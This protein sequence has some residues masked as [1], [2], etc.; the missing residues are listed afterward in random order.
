MKSPADTF[1]LICQHEVKT[2]LN[3]GQGWTFIRGTCST[4]W[5]TGPPRGVW[6]F[7]FE[8]VGLLIRAEFSR[9]NIAHTLKWVALLSLKYTC[10][11]PPST[12]PTA[13]HE[14][15]SFQLSSSAIQ[16]DRCCGSAFDSDSCPARQL[17]ASLSTYMELSVSNTT[18]QLHCSSPAELSQMCRRLAVHVFG[19]TAKL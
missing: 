8:G 7:F 19:S 4:R 9:S 10:C 15:D 14:A 2:N 5:A 16:P 3:C 1:A 18:G 13:M 11:A 12:P 6:T 17:N